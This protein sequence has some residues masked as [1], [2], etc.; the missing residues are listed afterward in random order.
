MVVCVGGAEGVRMPKALVTGV[1]GHIGSYLADRLIADDWDVMGIDDF[2]TG[3]REHVPPG[4]GLK[5]CDVGYLSRV[6]I[7]G[8]KPDVI[9]HLAAR[10]GPA[11]IVRDPWAC[12][13]QHAEHAVAVCELARDL[14]STVVLASSSE[15]YGYSTDTP[16]RE[17]Q[18]L[19]V[20]PSHLPRTAYA[21]SKLYVEHIGLSEYR[22]HATPVV[23]VRFFN[24][25]GA[26]QR[27]AFVLPIWI[28]AALQGHPI[29]IHG[30]GTQRRCF[31]HVGDAVEALVRLAAS[32]EAMGKIVNIGSPT[33]LTLSTLAR[34][35]RSHVAALYGKDP[36]PIEYVPYET[37]G[38]GAWEH[39]V[40]R[41]P[42]VSR[43]KELTG[44]V[45]PDRLSQ[46]IEDV[47]HDQARQLQD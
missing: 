39:F 47:A 33:T 6:G 5:E 15:V 31:T 36:V 34:L 35:V 28:R 3:K 17:D 27:P 42:D 26:R 9:F 18:P 11:D 12:L 30:D 43:L 7:Y 22:A 10:V 13:T 23:V 37:T 29:V 20:G 19:I 14:G 25:S 24:V 1:G 46:I 16:F 2:S 4:V 45:V 21:V 38:D 44:F 32:P 41:V 40:V 8:W